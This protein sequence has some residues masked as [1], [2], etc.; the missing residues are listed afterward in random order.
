MRIS[1]SALFKT[2]TKL[3]NK[4][5]NFKLDN[6]DYENQITIKTNTKLNTT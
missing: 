6:N 2:N 1:Q 5:K 3:H 4:N